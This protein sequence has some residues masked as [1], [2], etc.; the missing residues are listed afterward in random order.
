MRQ[1]SYDRIVSI[2]E[3]R[4]ELMSRITISMM[5]D[6]FLWMEL[7]IKLTFKML[8]I[9]NKRLLVNVKIPLAGFETTIQIS[10]LSTELLAARSSANDALIDGLARTIGQQR[11]SVN[12]PAN[13]WNRP[14]L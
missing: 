13:G 5:K 7:P 12:N 10:L 3:V 11:P 9:H 14:G 4:Y 6:A 1:S 2:T 8:H